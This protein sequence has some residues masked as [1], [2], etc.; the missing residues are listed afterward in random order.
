MVIEDNDPRDKDIWTGVARYW[1]SKASDKNPTTGRLYHHLAILARPNALQQ[2]Y[3]YAKSRYVVVPYV[4]ARE[5]IST[6]FNTVLNTDNGYGQYRLP[7]FNTAFIKVHGLLFTGRDPEN[8]ETS[9]EQFIKLLDNQIGRVIKKFMELHCYFQ[10]CSATRLC[11][12][13]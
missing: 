8:V 3:Y 12:K 9:I 4:S 1:Y 2:L 11:V 7:P 13:R 6:I 5:L 10:Q